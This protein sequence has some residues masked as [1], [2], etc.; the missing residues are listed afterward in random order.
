MQA[1][2]RRNGNMEAS[3]GQLDEVV[4]HLS[5]CW[6][7]PSGPVDRTDGAISRGREQT[8]Q[9]EQTRAGMASLSHARRWDA[10]LASPYR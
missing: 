6:R 1:K 8:E 4:E 5:A 7:T 9:T 2:H 10:S 3:L